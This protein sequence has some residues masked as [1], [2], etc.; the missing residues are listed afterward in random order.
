MVWGTLA[1][2]I[3]RRPTSLSCLFLLSLACVGLAFVPTTHFWLLLV[4][5][6]IQ[7]VGSAS[8]LT[9]GTFAEYHLLLC[10]ISLAIG[11]GIISDIA[12]PAERGGFFGMFTAGP[13]VSPRL[14]PLIRILFSKVGPALGPVIGGALADKLGWR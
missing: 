11:A 5:R 12:T 10:F 13:Q 1:D 8:T 4:L 9:I 2:R 14:Y 7:A 3:G 6:C